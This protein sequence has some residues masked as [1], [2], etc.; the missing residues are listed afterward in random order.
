MTPHQR[1]VT[2]PAR[3][4]EALRLLHA[5]RDPRL[6]ATLQ[7]ARDKGWNLALLAHAMGVTAER[8]RQIIKKGT[9][10]HA[11][12]PG[13]PE[14]PEPLPPAE[15]PG[16]DEL[17]LQVQQEWAEFRQAQQ[18]GRVRELYPPLDPAPPAKEE[19]EQTRLA[20]ALGK[21]LQAAQLDNLGKALPG[22][23]HPVWVVCTVC[24]RLLRLADAAVPAPCPHRDG[25]GPGW[26]QDQE[27]GREEFLRRMFEGMTFHPDA[28]SG[29][30]A[31]LDPEPDGTWALRVKGVP[32]SVAFSADESG[33]TPFAAAQLHLADTSWELP[34]DIMWEQ[35]G[36]YAH[37]EVPGGYRIAVTTGEISTVEIL[38]RGILTSDVER[39]E[40]VLV[41]RLNRW[42]VWDSGYYTS[43]GRTKRW[44][45][46]PRGALFWVLAER[47]RQEEAQT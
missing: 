14:A 9:G 11:P 40:T 6:P 5:D 37:D 45:V 10:G 42:Q 3:F 13:V 30:H 18:E 19:T 1:G 47:A 24:G 23:G 15:R 27:A 21:A 43:P 22:P 41:Q 34:G 4:S 39:R 29:F 25:A 8:P 46:F 44:Y 33:G 17:E 2:L 26:A 20:K 28:Y 32:G 36:F 12:I 16:A 38:E 7:D 35:P 31:W